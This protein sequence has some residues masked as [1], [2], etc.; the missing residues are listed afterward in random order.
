MRFVSSFVCICVITVCSCKK[1]TNPTTTSSPS[2]YFVNSLTSS[3]E[4]NSILFSSSDSA[5]YNMIVSST[6]LLPQSTTVTL[7]VGDDYRVS[8][9]SANGTD[10]QPMPANAY[11]FQSTFTAGTTG[12]YD[13]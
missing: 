1:D 10:Y 2:F 11:S 9:N 8:Y 4:D 6:L 12:I 3:F 7:S 5:T 13:T